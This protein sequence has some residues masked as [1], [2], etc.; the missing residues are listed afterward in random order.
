MTICPCCGFKF[1]GSLSQGCE[2]CGARSVG[3]PLPKPEH[4]LPSYGRSLLLSVTGVLMVL[5]FLVQTVIALFQRSAISFGFSSWLAAAETAAWRFKW[6]AVP[7]TILVVWGTR[8]LYRSMLQ[9]PAKYCGL[10]YARAG[11]FASATVPLVIALLIGVTVP[12]RLRQRELASE[13]AMNATAY[14]IDRILVQY[15]KE[16]GTFP[17]DKK[18]L[19]RLPDPDG[20]IAALIRELEFAEY[21]PSVDV[22][23]APSKNPQPRVPVIRNASFTPADDVPGESLS[24]MNYELR[25]PGADKI[26]GNEDDLI[27]KDGIISSASEEKPVTKRPT[28]VTQR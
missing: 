23:A 25:F 24:F 26:K 21:K 9:S 3:E 19:V 18:D 27:V 22:A 1:E 16:F 7:L 17:A 6:I 5:A 28:A 20:S 2:A 12:E 14:A 4:E 8:K 15:Q 11:F 10:R 13:A